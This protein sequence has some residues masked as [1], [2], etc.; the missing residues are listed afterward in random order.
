MTAPG[1]GA[2]EDDEAVACANARALGWESRDLL[3]ALQSRDRADLRARY[4][5]AVHRLFGEAGV[6]LNNALAELWPNR[7]P[8]GVGARCTSPAQGD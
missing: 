8:S 4:A 5:T 7:A 6:D 3:M 2:V 1:I